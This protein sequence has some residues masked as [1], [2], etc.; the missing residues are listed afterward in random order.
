[1]STGLGAGIE[2]PNGSGSGA[3]YGGNGGASASGAPGGFTYGSVQQPVDWGSRGGL[4]FG[5]FD[6]F[7]QG[8]GAIRL[9]VAGTLTVNGSV[10][11]NG[12]AAAFPNTGGGAGGSVWLSADTLAGNGLIAANGGA[13]EPTTGG[14]GG[15]GRIALYYLTNN[16]AGLTTALGATGA[17]PGQNGTVFVANLPTPQFTGQSPIGA[18]T[19]PVS[20]IAVSFNS[21]IN[22]AALPITN[23]TITTPG[24]VLSPGS[25]T[26]SSS[27]G[28][29]QDLSTIIFS[30][31]Q[32]IAVGT[33]STQI[34]PPVED[35]FGLFTTSNYSGSFS[36][37]Q[38]L[39]LGTI[40]DT[41]ANPIAGV[42]VQASGGGAGVTD[43]NGNYV[44][45][46]P[47]N[48]A[49][50]VTPSLGNL[51]FF[52]GSLSFTNLNQSVTNQNFTGVPPSGFVLQS[53]PQAG[54][55]YCG[56][57]GL[58][59][60]SYQIQYS[61]NM[62]TWLPYGAPVIGTNGMMNV[63]IPLDNSPQKFYRFAVA[64]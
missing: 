53:V 59:G 48:W 16:F 40:T 51:T 37:S 32:Q 54:I 36:I 19:G 28:Y 46:V 2:F 63:D 29:P 30:F 23:V 42:T 31:P 11:A 41:N 8:G 10:S 9:E 58:N 49:G 38:P 26:V 34:N 60:V 64:H 47:V 45:S 3:G 50:T 13:G 52:P 39:V 35:L 62:L 24:G 7:S 15:G 12:G 14:G 61:T 20:S 6:P 55:L 25:I 5:G 57:Y 56:W 17:S 22:P 1:L 33:Y 4:P 43:P 44:L 27:N 18:V 21:Q